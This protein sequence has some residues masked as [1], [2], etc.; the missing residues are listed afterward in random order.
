[1]YEAP[2]TRETRHLSLK[3]SSEGK[4]TFLSESTDD[5]VIT[6]T[7]EHFSFLKLKIWILVILKAALASQRQTSCPYKPLILQFLSNFQMFICLELWQKRTFIGDCIGDQLRFIFEMLF[8]FFKG[9]I[10]SLLFFLLMDTKHQLIQTLGMGVSAVLWSIPLTTHAILNYLNIL[11][12]FFLILKK[13][14]V[15]M[16]W[17]FSIKTMANG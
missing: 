6:S 10:W 1:M 4:G 14:L 16:I 12:S 2:L 11:G 3:F 8:Y 13:N 17:D 7:D 9:I 5:F 15:M